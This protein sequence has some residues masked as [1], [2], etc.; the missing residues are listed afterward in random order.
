MLWHGLVAPDL[1]KDML[2]SKAWKKEK[3]KQYNL[4]AEP[5]APA[6]STLFLVPA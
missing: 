2:E 6:V 4:D 1:T 3:F 5:T